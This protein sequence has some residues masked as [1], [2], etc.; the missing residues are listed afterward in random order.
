M[1]GTIRFSHPPDIEPADAAVA[2][3]ADILNAMREKRSVLVEVQ[4]GTVTRF[5][6]VRPAIAS[7]GELVAIP[8]GVSNPDPDPGNPIPRHLRQDLAKRGDLI[9]P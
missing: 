9:A 2:T 1:E 7:P 5:F 4:H 3:I 8:V 6:D